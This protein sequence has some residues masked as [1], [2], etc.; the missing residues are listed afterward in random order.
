MKLAKR[1][2]ES[3]PPGGA[4]I[5]SDAELADLERRH[6][7]G[8]SAQ[9]VV[10]LVA[11]RGHRISEAS[12]R[13]YVQQGLLP[14]S[15]RV[16]RKDKR[17]GSL[18]LYP[19]T[20]LRQLVRLRALMAQGFTIEEIRS[21]FL[22]V[23]ADIEALQRQLERVFASLASAYERDAFGPDQTVEFTLGQARD[24]GATLLRQL[25]SIEDRLTTRAR[26]ARAA[27]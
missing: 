21:E 5:F 11:E 6:P 15:R 13:K 17:R 3:S 2:T 22:F 1:N 4:A 10:E 20:V 12:F 27:V 16:A 9:Q 25:E 24:A 14:R 8:L 18:G 23:R 7:E 19:V 26:M